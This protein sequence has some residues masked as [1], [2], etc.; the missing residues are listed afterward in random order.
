METVGFDSPLLMA[1]ESMREPVLDMLLAKGA[2]I[3]YCTSYSL[4][5]AYTPLNIAVEQGDI[6]VVRKLLQHGADPNLSFQHER[7]NLIIAASLGYVDIVELLLDSGTN[8]LVTK[9][10][11][12]LGVSENAYQIAMR[13]GHLELAT[14]L[15]V[16]L[17][18]QQL[19]SK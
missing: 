6:Q 16:R 11:E 4:K 15:K 12:K 5:A 1:V 2:R 13:E 17:W 19:V 14:L 10:N 8:G 7:Y 3:N 9:F 18:Q